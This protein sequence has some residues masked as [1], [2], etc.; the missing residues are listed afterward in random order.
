MK[1]HRINDAWN[2][3]GGWFIDE[4]VCDLIVQDFENRKSMWKESHSVRG[5]KVLHNQ[6]M[7]QALMD[8]YQMKVSLVLE[9]Y[10]RY[11]KY[12]HET[13][14]AFYM[15]EPWN[16][17]KYEVGK[18]YSAWHCEN[19]GDPKFR[20]RHLAFMTY[21]N[22]VTDGGETEFLYQNVKIR[23]EKGL[24]LIWPAHFT[25]THCGHPSHTQEKYVTTGW[26]EFFDTENFLNEAESAPN[27]DFFGKLDML[28]RKVS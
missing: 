21:L 22:D 4:Q 14:E 27:D 20:Y 12:S 11:Y 3:I 15:S 1:A 9:E 6:M 19:N 25:H 18:H 26:F 2:F 10:K 13:I 8:T 16:I 7:N 23:P 24:T 5:Y 17:Q 28:H